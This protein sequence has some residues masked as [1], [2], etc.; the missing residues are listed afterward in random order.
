MDPDDIYS[1]L[2]TTSS[3]LPPPPPLPLPSSLPAESALLAE[4]AVLRANISA[5]YRTAA[6]EIARKD[7]EIA[8]LGRVLEGMGGGGK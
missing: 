6:A 2:P 7:E 5:L 8:R 3:T 4:N 1:D